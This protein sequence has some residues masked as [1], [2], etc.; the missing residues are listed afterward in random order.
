MV[1]SIGLTLEDPYNHDH[2]PAEHVVSLMGLT[3]EDPTTVLH[4]SS[5]TPEKSTSCTPEQWSLIRI[6]T[7]RNVFLISDDFNM[8]TLRQ[9]VIGSKKLTKHQRF[10]ILDQ[11][12]LTKHQRGFWRNAHRDTGWVF[13]IVPKN[14]LIKMCQ[15]NHT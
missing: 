11:H 2:Q 3:L 4:L 10:A 6:I 8:L 14:H 1:I 15:Q 13:S 7:A 12:G 9:L 5:R